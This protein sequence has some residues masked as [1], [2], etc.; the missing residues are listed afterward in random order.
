MNAAKGFVLATCQY[1]M[2]GGEAQ[3][4]NFADEK[5][6][7]ITVARIRHRNR[8]AISMCSP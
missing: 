4:T 6:N 3:V 8:P 2:S 7:F 5:R 1:D